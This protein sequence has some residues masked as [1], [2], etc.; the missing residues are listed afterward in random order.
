[1]SKEKKPS[2]LGTK[3]Q[4]AV[5]IFLILA[6]MGGFPELSAILILLMG[7][8]FLPL[9]QLQQLK[10][11]WI[12][13]KT[14]RAVAATAVLLLAIFLTPS[15]TDTTVQ[16]EQDST[17]P[18]TTQIQESTTT[19]DNTDQITVSEPIEETET[20]PKVTDSPIVDAPS[21]GTIATDPNNT[22]PSESTSYENE[23]KEDTSDTS[24]PTDSS[25][26]I[27]F[28]DVGQADAALIECDGEFMLVDGGNVADSS[29]IYSVL[30]SAGADHLS[31]ILGSH[32][33]EDHIG[34]L[35]AAYQ[36]AD[37]DLTLCPVTTHDSDAFKN[38]AKYANQNGGITIPSIGDTYTLGRATVSILGINGG[39]EPNDSSIIFRIDYGQ[40]SFLFTGDAE[41]EAE[42]AVLNS[43]ADLSATV[44]KVGHHGSNTS[45]TYPFLREIMPQYAVISVGEGN[46]YG[47]PTE[48]TLSRLRDADVQVYRTDMQG[49]VICIS[50]GT[51]VSFSVERNS[52]ADVLGTAGA[53]ASATEAPTEFATEAPT[54]TTTESTEETTEETSSGTDYIVNKNTGKFHHTWCSSV[55]QMSEKNKRYYTGDRDDLV[56]QG[57][58]PC[59]RCNP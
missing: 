48:D 44:L 30:K 6:G 22:I 12:P 24:I 50:D 29:V 57:Y 5:S 8:W 21:V 39:S 59:K 27:H 32:L 10:Q 47:H 54:D 36:Y 18:A 2:T 16:S 51:A 25:F 1:M 15:T 20:E 17:T 31:I 19:E 4:W 13:N 34:G 46:S 37:V 35:A 41:R 38:F 52:D 7:V 49:D 14:V 28:I 55:D 33:H 26:S 3:I 53:S 23:K 58:E 43:G 11:K 9:Q 42:Q 40:T 56:S 45:T